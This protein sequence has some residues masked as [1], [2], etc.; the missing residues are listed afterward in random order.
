MEDWDF[1]KRNIMRQTFGKT[2]E[3]RAALSLLIGR[4][5]EPVFVIL[6]RPEL[7]TKDD[8]SEYI[9]TMLAV[10]K[11]TQGVL[12]V[13]I[14]IRNGAWD[15]EQDSRGIAKSKLLRTLCLDQRRV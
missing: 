8:A 9:R 11:E 13:L 5:T 3:L 6:N 15:I 10:A 7:S 2:K 14:V 12:K 1:L 4:Q